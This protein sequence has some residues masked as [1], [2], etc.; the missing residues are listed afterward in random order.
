MLE[1]VAF[2]SKVKKKSL[3]MSKRKR[4]KGAEGQ[5]SKN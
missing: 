3:K 4:R 1:I 2:L 5:P